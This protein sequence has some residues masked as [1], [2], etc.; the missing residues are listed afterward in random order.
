MCLTF[1][2]K[3]NL[4]TSVTTWAGRRA[5]EGF[6]VCLCFCNLGKTDPEQKTEYFQVNLSEFVHAKIENFIMSKWCVIV[7]IDV[8]L[9]CLFLEPELGVIL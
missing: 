5:Y 4:G 2:Q 1:L 7:D 9:I 6:M 3:L 8:F